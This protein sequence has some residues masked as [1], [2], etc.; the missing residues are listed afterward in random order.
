MKR[1]DIAGLRTGMLSV[2]H[3]DAADRCNWI[4]RCDCGCEVSRRTNALR[5]GRA[6]SCMSAGCRLAIVRANLKTHGLTDTPEYVSW[7]SMIQR[8]TNSK[9]RGF[10]HYGGRGISICDQWRHSFETFLA[11]MGPRPDGTSIDRIDVDGNYEPSN[12]RWATDAQQA[13]NRTNRKLRPHQIA[14]IRWLVSVGMPKTGIGE[15]FGVSDSMV[16]AIVM[17]QTWVTP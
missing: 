16:Y 8:C 9:R 13:R 14:Q 1:L 11:D 6:Q 4:A 5:S 12:C 2:L 3:R 7:S 15:V 17:G 10:R